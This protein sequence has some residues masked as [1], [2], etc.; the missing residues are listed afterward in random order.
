M[1][2][3][4]PLYFYIPFLHPKKLSTFVK[5][6]DQKIFEYSRKIDD[7]IKSYPG[8]LS[9]KDARIIKARLYMREREVSVLTLLGRS[10]DSRCHHDPTFCVGQLIANITEV[11]FGFI[12]ASEPLLNSDDI[13]SKLRSHLDGSTIML[14]SLE[15]LPGTKAMN[16]FQF[17][18]RDE[19]QNRRGMLLLTLYTGPNSQN[20]KNLTKNAE[21][22]ERILAEK[23]SPYIPKDTLTSVISRICGSIVKVQ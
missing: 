17:I 7:I 6:N 10:R 12:D 20:N 18:D 14:D 9:S 13:E 4:L 19:L 5:Q 21:L 11:Q 3:Y 16:L 8:S 2:F 15:R 23:W 1:I 22:V